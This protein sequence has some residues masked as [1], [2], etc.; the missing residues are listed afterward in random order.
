[1][2]LR[3]DISF[4][5][6]IP[7]L[8]RLEDNSHCSGPLKR[9]GLKAASSDDRTCMHAA[10]EYSVEEEKKELVDWTLL[11]LRKRPHDSFRFDAW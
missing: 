4:L 10:A 5:L 11:T 8:F 2:V 6:M 1:M 3:P 7:V 9:S